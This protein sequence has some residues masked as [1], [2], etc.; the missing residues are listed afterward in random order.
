MAEPL[1]QVPAEN[2]VER[3]VSV[4]NSSPGSLDWTRPFYTF[5]KKMPENNK[6]IARRYLQGSTAYAHIFKVGVL[7]P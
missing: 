2:H 7:D 3:F 1:F 5:G 6:A 4:T